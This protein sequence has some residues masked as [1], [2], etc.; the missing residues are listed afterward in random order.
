[1]DQD[2][3]HTL[4]RG[5]TRHDFCRVSPDATYPGQPYRRGIDYEKK[6]DEEER[7]ITRTMQCTGTGPGAGISAAGKG[8]GAREPRWER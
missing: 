6:M 7:H 8:V 2:F 4:R 1:M 3:Y 5:A